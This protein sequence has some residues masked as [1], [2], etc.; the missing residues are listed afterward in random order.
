MS[1]EQDMNK[2][3]STDTLRDAAAVI[4]AV[5]EVGLLFLSDTKRR[6][7]IEIL[8]GQFPRG[9]WWSHPQANAIYDILQDV[10]RHPDLLSAKLLSGKVTFVH[11]RLW[12]ALL[13]VV[14]AREPWQ[15]EGMPPV[16]QQWLA[17]FDEAE[18]AGAPPPPVSRT[19]SKEI[20]ARLLAYAESVHT[21]AGRH[22][23]RLESWR[24]WAARVGVPW[25]PP[26]Q[27]EAPSLED[28]K[29]SLEAAAAGLGPPPADLPWV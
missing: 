2:Q 26:A 13:T 29:R 15:T 24:A 25:P 5:A 19:V 11:R 20:E 18:A 4:A 28:A 12:P 7:A 9:S 16:A 22:E 21:T 23:T 10:E 27:A 17:A 1:N 6:N 3:P 8:T 14:T